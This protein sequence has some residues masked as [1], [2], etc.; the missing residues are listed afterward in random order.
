MS[1]IL[2]HTGT[3]SDLAFPTI[4]GVT[5]NGSA[6]NRVME[7]GGTG[8]GTQ[9][10]SVAGGATNAIVAYTTP[11]GHLNGVT[12]AAGNY[13]IRLNLSAVNMT[14]NWSRVIVRRLNSA[15]TLQATISDQSF[16]VAMGTASIETTVSGIAQTFSAGDRLQ[17]VYIATNT[18]AMT[19]QTFT[20]AHTA[21]IDTPI[22]PAATAPA[23]PAAPTITSE[24][25]Q[26][27]SLSWTAPSDGGSAILEYEVRRTPGSVTQSAGTSTTHTFTG[28]TNGTSYTFAVRAR[29]AVGWG[30]YSPE[31][32]SATPQ[33]PEVAAQI[34][35][36]LPAAT[37]TKTA[38]QVFPLH[39][40]KDSFDAGLNTDIW[41]V[42]NGTPAGANAYA[43]VTDGEL[44]INVGSTGTGSTRYKGIRTKQSNYTLRE[45]SW[46]VTLVEAASKATTGMGLLGQNLHY[47]M[48]VSFDTESVRNLQ[49]WKWADGTGAFMRSSIP[50]NPAVHRH[51]RMRETGGTIFF[52]T[53]VD[54]LSWTTHHSETAH[55][56]VASV[57][58]YLEVGFFSVATLLN[59]VTRF[60]NLN[61][62]PPLK[63]APPA[64]V[65]AP[66]GVTLSW[67][68]STGTTSQRVERRKAVITDFKNN[69]FNTDLFQLRVPAPAAMSAQ[70]TNE[71]VRATR[72]AT[73][74]TY[75][76][77][78]TITENENVTGGS[79]QGELSERFASSSGGTNL[80]SD[81][82]FG[83]YNRIWD[84][85]FFEVYANNQHL[86]TRRINGTR[87]ILSTTTLTESQARFYRVREKAGTI[88]FETAPL[89]AGG[90]GPG[91][92]TL[93]HS[94]AIPFR[95]AQM[96]PLAGWGQ[97]AG[98]T[99]V[100]NPSSAWDNIILFRNNWETVAT[101][102]DSATT[103]EDTSVEEGLYEYR[104]VGVN[105]DGST[106]SDSSEALV[107]I[108]SAG[109]IS[110]TLPAATSS[111]TGT[112]TDPVYT[113]ALSRTL[114]ALTSAKT[115]TSEGLPE[116][117]GPWSDPVSGTTNV[118]IVTPSAPVLVSATALGQ[119]RVDLLWQKSAGAT[120][121]R[122]RRRRKYE[123]WSQYEPH[124][125]YLSHASAGEGMLRQENGTIATWEEVVNPTGTK[126]V[127]WVDGTS[128]LD[129]NSG[130]TSS[131]P[132]KTFAGVM[133]ILTSTSIVVIRGG[134]Y[135][136]A[137]RQTVGGE[138]ISNRQ[139]W[140]A[141]PGETVTISGSD[142]VDDSGVFTAEANGV[143][144]ILWT[145][146]RKKNGTTG[147][148]ETWATLNPA[149]DSKRRE[150][151]VYNNQPLVSQ[152]TYSGT[153]SP[154]Q[155]YV[156][157]TDNANRGSSTAVRLYI[158]LQGDA[159][160][161]TAATSGL[162]EVG[163]RDILFGASN[164]SGHNC[165]ELGRAFF[166][167]IGLNF[168]HAA[169]RAQRPGIC[170]G[171]QGSLFEEITVEW[172]GGLGI[173]VNGPN[174]IIRACRGND[175]GQAGMGGSGVHGSLFE[176]CETSRNN[177]R[178]Y[179]TGWEAGGFK[180]VRT[181]GATWK[182]HVALD[183]NGVGMWLDYLNH[184]NTIR[185]SFVDNNMLAGIFIEY[186]CNGNKVFN[187]VAC[188]TRDAGA[189]WPGDGIIVQG[190]NNIVAHN[191][192]VLNKGAGIR[193]LT[194]SRSTTELVTT[195]MSFALSDPM[196]AWAWPGP[197]EDEASKPDPLVLN[198]G[199][200]IMNKCLFTTIKNNLHIDNGLDGGVGGRDLALNYGS[201]TTDYSGT[202]KSA[203]SVG[204]RWGYLQSN[205]ING[206]VYWF[207]PGS[208][209]GIYTTFQT[210]P[211]TA[212]DGNN[213]YENLLSQFQS[214]T[215]KEPNGY[216]FTAGENE[217][218]VLNRTERIRG[219][220]LIAGSAAIGKGVA[221]PA[222]LPL[223]D[224]YGNPRPSTAPDTGAHQFTG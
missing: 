40:I 182:G 130:L 224:L 68:P 158:R 50:Y 112:H 26:Q 190:I 92:W 128:G 35:R 109:T 10:Y 173:R 58:F 84:S 61:L 93:R 77:F 102:M 55:S 19:A 113:G 184:E 160:P 189:N 79:I 165:G 132:K 157:T 210:V 174:H 39:L 3:A 126:Q 124:S 214:R 134:Y 99:T 85:Y 153:L 148:V 150:F 6:V 186:N 15:G 32:A 9:A 83:A 166:R 198:P 144:S 30:N 171:A 170:S 193:T 185:D 7:I 90:T 57:Q 117:F 115:G 48:E 121:Y 94:S 62:A 81:I 222:G 88:F 95:V 16:T 197:A 183:N 23:A 139:V 135:R 101:L 149:S 156:D 218:S 221:V 131:L 38:A 114:P 44:R 82:G 179:S 52:E 191:T 4:A 60:D 27:V 18:N 155:F 105:A 51:F 140:M 216:Q 74:E 123:L 129:T 87:T 167:L 204:E 172:C 31:S 96:A 192:T 107:E 91:A 143:W 207:R 66:L 154:G 69:L 162:F 1:I 213:A 64:A 181:V 33:V 36:T 122:V 187:N 34:S 211:R 203:Y 205:D 142:L 151:F 11:S 133:P 46:S 103:Y 67:T 159:N 13:I 73:T 219:W 28:L 201:V 200:R 104:I 106:A 43:D 220:R 208:G 215:G 22:T 80:F 146:G 195:Q 178:G 176:Y 17:V 37:S 20:V 136:E 168:R 24:G 164:E 137:I 59:G 14:M 108:D 29:N 141:F 25:N 45:S 53:S 110:R 65:S 98:T 145:A 78:E 202:A 125:T 152:D 212:S 209:T 47:S 100:T 118:L 199:A 116:T 12:G 21:D 194:D 175:N 8:S 63:P 54:G 56:S 76:K 138:S 188:R 169:N 49:F 97:F 206:N 86:A 2:N 196:Y 72:N 119:S 127:I 177:W 41:E 70:V 223:V 5:N 111:K 71:E 120:G 147:A 163:Q 42:W 161:N 180:F 217:A 75:P 89:S